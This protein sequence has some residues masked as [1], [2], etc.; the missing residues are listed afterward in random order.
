[1]KTIDREKFGR[2]VAQRRKELGLTQQELAERLFLSNKAVSKW[3]TGQSL[4]DIALLEPLAQCLE[5]SVA[6]LLRGERIEERPLEPEETVALVD[7]AIHF[8]GGREDARSGAVRRR[9]RVGWLIS[10]VLGAAGTLGLCL[11]GYRLEDL[12]SNVLLVE[13]LCLVFGLW[14]VFFAP[15][16]LPRYYDENKVTVFGQGPVRLNLAGIRFH[17]GNWPHILAALRWWLVVVPAVF[18]PLYGLLRAAVPQ[19]GLPWELGVT[20]TAALGLFVP[21]MVVAKRYE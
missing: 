8:A 2:F 17:N 6:E 18:P 7:Q 5:V 13:L 11:L 21:V 12:T 20:L 9:W 19:W 4:P 3:E 1:M 10:A 16:R 15:E 14:V